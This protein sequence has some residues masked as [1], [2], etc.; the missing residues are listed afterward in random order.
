ME[1]PVTFIIIFTEWKKD[2]EICNMGPRTRIPMYPFC[3]HGPYILRRIGALCSQT[4]GLPI[5]MS[6]C[7]HSVTFSNFA[8]K[9]DRLLVKN[10]RFTINEDLLK[11]F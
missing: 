7:P 9:Y 10:L 5:F 11:I 6:K 3:L 4:I 1:D 8:S 2:V